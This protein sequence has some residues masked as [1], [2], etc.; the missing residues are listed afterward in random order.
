M[1]GRTP[2]HRGETQTCGMLR[3]VDVGM[4]VVV[5]VVRMVVV[6]VGFN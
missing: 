6:V 5:V 3:L 2:S 1:T 4:V